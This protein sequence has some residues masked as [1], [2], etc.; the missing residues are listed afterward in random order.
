MP[1][2]GLTIADLRDDLGH[3]AAGDRK[4]GENCGTHGCRLK[5]SVRSRLGVVLLNDA[6]AICSEVLKAK[7]KA[8]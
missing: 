3:S 1:K 4:D 2:R 5:Y 7:N 8:R 6:I